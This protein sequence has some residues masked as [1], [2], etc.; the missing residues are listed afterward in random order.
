M[1]TPLTPQPT[2][3]RVM[4]SRRSANTPAHALT[5]E[6][7]FFMKPNEGTWVQRSGIAILIFR[8][9]K[10]A[11]KGLVLLTITL[12]TFAASTY[13]Q[14]NFTSLDYPGGTL[15]AARGI[16]DR[17]DIVGAYR[18]V[19]PRHALLIRRGQFIP[20][21][22]TTI[23]GSNASEAFKSNDLGDAVG[24]LFGNDGFFHGFLVRKGVVTTLD[25]PGASD[26]SF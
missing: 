18:T 10:T 16:N 20:L 24:E 13:A 21:A 22:P 14:L 4:R 3:Y 11:M 9:W 2:K 7:K 15:T 17:G 6:R 12:F 5:Y 1:R 8:R 25:F 19:A 23:L 26:T